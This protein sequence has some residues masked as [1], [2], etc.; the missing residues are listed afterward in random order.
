MKAITTK[1][2][3]IGAIL[4]LVLSHVALKAQPYY[5]STCTCVSNN[6]PGY[7]YTDK[8]GDIKCHKYH[9][10]NAHIDPPGPCACD[11]VAHIGTK[12]AEFSDGVYPNPVS[13]SATVFLTALERQ[14]V[15]LR[16][17]DSMGKLVSTLIDGFVDRGEHKTEWDATRVLAGVYLLRLQTAGSMETRKL[18]VVK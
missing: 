10:N 15:S 18:L 2:Y 17:F 16:I 6:P 1:F 4:V 3:R 13:N 8:N 5:Y 14:K 12:D 11:P 7:C 9:T